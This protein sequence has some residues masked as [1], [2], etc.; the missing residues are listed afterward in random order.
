[1]HVRP[2]LK[3]LG[4]SLVVTIAAS[5]A[6]VT[7]GAARPDSGPTANRAALAPNCKT[8]T[9][10]I[11]AP[12]TGQVA[13]LGLEQRNW[14]RYAVAGHTTEQ[15]R[16]PAN[17]RIIFRLVEGDTQL[18]PAQASTVG[19][20]FA[21]DSSILGVIGPA[22]SQ[23]VIA[24]DP[25]FT[26]A[27]MPFISGSAT[28]TTLTDG[29]VPTFFRVVPNDSV[30]GPTIARY[31]RTRLNARRV[32]IVDDQT[33][34]GQPL[35]DGIAAN[36]RAGGVTVQRESINVETTSDFSALATR[37][38]TD[39]QFVVLAW[40]IAAKAQVFGQQLK[41]QGKSARIFG[42][43]GL[44]SPDAFKIDGSFI[45]SFA[46]DIRNIASSKKFVTGYVKLFPNDQNFGTF[47]PPA[48]S[49]TRAMINAVVNAC[50]DGRVTRSEVLAQVKRTSI[51]GNILG[52][53]LRFT[54]KGDVQG[55]RFF[56]FEIRNG[57]YV[58]VG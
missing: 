37:V 12:I 39:T 10:A 3:Q 29:S 25:I 41:Q 22:G 32:V 49:A 35:A 6:V 42:T 46:P 4:A 11:Q 19:Q 48:F 28:R 8:P 27:K 34:Y 53:T 47:G 1:M 7:S 50:K 13:F 5:L 52:G 33:A 51:P 18:N 26:R 14:A 30:Q 15:R 16:L 44:F 36:L 43:D 56:I 23:E 57:R 40:Q 38:A 21:S 2:G 20:R 58:T 9:I 45:S 31:L 17:R 54:A 55:A 24:V